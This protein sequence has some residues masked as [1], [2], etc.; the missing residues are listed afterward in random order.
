[1]LLIPSFAKH[2]TEQSHK[3]HKHLHFQIT[4]TLPQVKPCIFFKL[5]N[6]WGWEPKPV[7]CGDP[8]KIAEDGEKF[9]FC[10]ETLKKHMESPAAK[11]AKGDSIWIDCNGR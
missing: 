6:I 11:E 2:Q 1:M 7:Q 10:P 9:D 5:N 8:E 3:E 4:K